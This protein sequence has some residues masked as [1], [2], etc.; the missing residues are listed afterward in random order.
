MTND[1]ERSPIRVLVDA[2]ACPVKNE[3]YKV[4]A[5]HKVRTS[6]VANS[7]MQVPS[8]PLIERVVVPSGLDVAD[9]WIAERA[10]RG[11]VVVTTDVPLAARCVKSGADVIAPTGKAFTE[12]SIGMALATRN[13][14]DQLRSAGEITGGP[15]PFASGDRSAFLSALDLAITRLKRAG[16][17]PD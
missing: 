10:R 16:F 8:D 1:V 7:W 12:Q 3:V 15:R 5:R 6:V 9:D 13:L 4:A 2:D 11:V 17:Q 14:M